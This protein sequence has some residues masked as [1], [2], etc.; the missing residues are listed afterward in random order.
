MSKTIFAALAILLVAS[1]AQAQTRSAVKA[2]GAEIEKHCG[3]VQPGDG[4]VRDCVKAHLKEFSPN[5]QAVFTHVSTLVKACASDTKQNC[6]GVR[7]GGSRIEVCLKSHMSSL[8]SECK[9][10]LAATPPGR[11]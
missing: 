1:A 8:S 3:N 11:S 2:C 4:A 10:A 7:P 6:A 5:C 9:A